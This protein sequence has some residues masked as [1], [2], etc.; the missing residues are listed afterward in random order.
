MKLS[1]SYLRALLWTDPQVLLATA[2]YGA[3]SWSVSRRDPDGSRQ[4]A[5]AR[6]WA[7]RLLSIARVE[8]EVDGRERLPH[9][10]AVL[11]ANHLSYFDTP[12][13]FA[14]LDLPFRILAL[15]GLFRIPFLG[16]HLRR[17]QHIPVVQSDPRAAMRSLLRAAER[18]KRGESV[19]IFPEAHR[20]LSGELQPFFSGAF[21]LALKA[22]VPVVPLALVGTRE[23]LPPGSH[24]L[25]PGRVRLRVG[26][27][28]A[29]TGLDSSQAAALAAQARARIGHLLIEK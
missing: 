1:A 10:P 29:T 27:P 9:P 16:G 7:R 17:A 5:I 21:L 2:A 8:V 6:R 25:R 24:H 11:V 19:F 3:W 14:E 18:V 15:D 20:S 28:I 22:Q 4:H 23:I 26:A 13:I 12:V